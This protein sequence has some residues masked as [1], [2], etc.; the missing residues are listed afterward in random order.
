MVVVDLKTGKDPLSGKELAA[1]PQLRLYQYAVDSGLVE[2]VPAQARSAG[3]ELWQL[4]ATTGDA[5]RVQRQSAHADHA[6]VLGQMGAA[7]L[8]ILNESFPAVPERQRCD[9][10]AYRIACPAVSAGEQVVA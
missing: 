5:V 10:C 1:S 6:E 4:R 2:G 9:R 8:A 3:G 7:R